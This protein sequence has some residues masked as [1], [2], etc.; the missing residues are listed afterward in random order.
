MKTLDIKTAA[1]HIKQACDDSR[2]S[3]HRSPFFFLVG[4]GISHPPIPLASEI[5]AKCK[6]IAA[7]HKRTAEP[8]DTRAIEKYS[9]W[10][11]TA[12]PQPV[13]RQ[14]FLRQLIE[15]KP[16]S[17]ANL[18]LAHLLLGQTITN[19]VVTTNFDDLLSRALTL[20][21]RPHIICDHPNTVER[22]DPE[23]QDLQLVH[24]HGT[25]W[26]YD[27][28]NLKGELQT[29]AKSSFHT[30]LTMASLLDNI[31]SHRSP[32]VIG[33]SGWEGD[34]FMGALQRRLQTRLPFN[35][36]W[37]C[38][39]LNAPDFLPDWLKLH[40][41]VYLVL[42][43]SKEGTLQAS[44]EV[45]IKEQ[46]SGEQIDLAASAPSKLLSEKE[47]GEPVLSAQQVLDELI[48]SFELPAPEL[49][50][51]PLS[52]FAK[53]LRSSL[54]HGSTGKQ[55][56]DF[57]FIDSV[58]RRIERATQ[59]ENE[60]FQ[61]IESQ[62][63]DV[64]DALRR[65]QYGE[66]ITKALRIQIEDLS[67]VQLNELMGATQAASVGLGDDSPEELNGHQLVA[68]LAEQLLKLRPEDLHLE[69]ILAGTSVDK[70]ITLMNQ[71]R[72]IDAIT[73]FEEVMKRFGERTEDAIV[74]LVANA[75]TFKAV[76]LSAIDREDDA[77]ATYDEI[78]KR[79]NHFSDPFF[80]NC[81]GEAI[82]DKGNLLD[83]RGQKLE[84]ISAYD[85]ILKR[86]ENLK[87]GALPH[88]LARTLIRKGIVLESL[89]RAEEALVAYEEVNK[90]LRDAPVPGLRSL[91]RDALRR[92]GQR[93]LLLNRPADAMSTFQQVLQIEPKDLGAI[94]GIGN[95]LRATGQYQLAIETYQSL[96]SI[97]PKHASAH[98]L[99]AQAQ[100]DLGKYADATKSLGQ[101]ILARPENGQPY[102]ELADLHCELGEFQNARETCQNAEQAIRDKSLIPYR[103]ALV[104]AA[105]QNY[106]EAI[107]LTEQFL[108]ERGVNAARASYMLLGDIYVYLGQFD[109]ANVAYSKALESG[110][111]A[112]HVGLGSLKLMAGQLEDAEA[113]FLKAS[114]LLPNAT[115]PRFNLAIVYGITGRQ[116]LADELFNEVIALFPSNMRPSRVLRRITALAGLR[117]YENAKK[118]LLDLFLKVPK[119]ANTVH[120][121]LDDLELMSRMPATKS[122]VLRFRQ[123]VREI[124]GL[125]DE[126]SIHT[127]S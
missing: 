43:S 71:D 118:E 106:A 65:S 77:L 115:G 124:L 100:F 2:Q 117:K 8:A 49:T 127:P 69:V 113:S 119:L 41:D 61:T 92:I 83:R 97:N 112:A 53:Y 4:A 32:I 91:R 81:V 17:H 72:T 10:F 95:T 70:G 23:L 58:I 20:F 94:V 85:T 25:Y 51:H 47:R 11:G 9:H 125:K 74:R 46:Q 14:T 44:A 108:L 79:Y 3:K 110:S 5:E 120:D 103:K 116:E 80:R 30:T 121:F 15:N 42:P 73:T 59:R 93:L 13:Q 111:K 82:L 98:T 99:T 16:I 56:G 76:G 107:R 38:H 57:Y 78:V 102:F 34:V 60:S 67:E 63:E 75:L 50:L 123:D 55:E 64:R 21:G 12:F 26:F 104:E 29:R 88:L 37:F 36:Y 66:G 84:A 6:A 27:C 31:L 86:F 40:E 18:R 96:L 48:Q 109:S 126:Q 22:I 122:D 39:R 101:A 62:L 28:C 54:P 87:E 35:L 33:Y 105:A 19:L 7:K 52:F 45:Q 114:K 90:R 1:S 24:V 68:S 89:D